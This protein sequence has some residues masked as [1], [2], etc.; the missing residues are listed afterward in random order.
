MEDKILAGLIPPRL[1]SREAIIE[2][3]KNLLATMQK[4]LTFKEQSSKL[5][6][7]ILVA[8]FKS[9]QSF[10]D[11]DIFTDILQD[12]QV[13]PDLLGKTTIKFDM[14]SREEIPT[15]KFMFY[16]DRMTENQ[17]RSEFETVMVDALNT[18]KQ[19]DDIKNNT[20]ALAKAKSMIVPHLFDSAM[21]SENT[22]HG[23]ITTERD[24]LMAEYEE[25]K[26]T[27]GVV[28]GLSTGFTLI[29]QALEAMVPGQLIVLAGASGEGKSWMATNIAWHVCVALKKNVV[30][31]TAETIRS[32]Y[33]RRVITRHSNLPKF[34]Y[35]LEFSKIKN[36]Q[37]SEEEE[38]VFQMV[39]DDFTS[40]E[41][42]SLEISQ[43]SNGT[44]LSDIRIYLEQLSLYKR[45]DLV[46]L[47]YLT[48]LKPTNKKSSQR[49][50]AVELFKE[51]KQLAVTFNNGTGIPVLTLHQISMQ[52]REKVKFAP[53]KFYSLA[54]LADSSE[55]GK[56]ADSCFALLRTEEMESEHEI[57]VGILKTRDSFSED[58][59]F[60]VFENFNYGFIGNL[61]ES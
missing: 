3:K 60:K 48:L 45:P 34:G 13:E 36:G 14:L 20:T 32:Q 56:S 12:N 4:N 38:E 8:Y 47:D 24:E 39:V 27:G 50:E 17:K 9:T 51:A 19:G 31:I 52:A 29:D 30:V 61:E 42:G 1:D 33:R 57:G 5:I 6:Y 26:R 7:Q 25:A 22:P 58:K 59:L 54:S 41:Y 15:D 46:I 35:P 11:T 21:I 18:L 44:T 43:V 37:L 28:D 49:E 16:L 53:G 55:A 23:D 2:A 10:P 40:G